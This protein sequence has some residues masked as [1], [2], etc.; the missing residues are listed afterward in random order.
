MDNSIQNELVEKTNKSIDEIYAEFADNDTVLHQL[1][2]GQ[3]KQ[4]K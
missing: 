4:Q 3:L 2:F 1:F